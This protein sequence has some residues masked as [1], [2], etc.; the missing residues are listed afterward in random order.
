[1]VP[2]GKEIRLKE[3]DPAYTG[4][5]SDKTAAK[6]ALLE[7]VSERLR[8][9]AGEVNSA[10]HAQDQARVDAGMSRILES[11]EACHAKFRQP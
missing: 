6:D 7:D 1:M 11:C 4:G 5:I 2:P 9:A 3:Y 10:V 8:D